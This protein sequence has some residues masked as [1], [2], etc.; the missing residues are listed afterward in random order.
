MSLVPH[1]AVLLQKLPVVCYKGE[2]HI[3]FRSPETS[4]DQSISVHMASLRA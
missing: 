3:A 2:H 4:Y 1:F